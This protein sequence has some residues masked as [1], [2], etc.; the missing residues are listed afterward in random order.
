MHRAICTSIFV[1][2]AAAL[3][4]AGCKPRQE[5]VSGEQLRNLL[6]SMPHSDRIN[7][8]ELAKINNGIYLLDVRFAEEH[9]LYLVAA[10]EIRIEGFSPEKTKLPMLLTVGDLAL[11]TGVEPNISY[12]PFVTRKR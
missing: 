10:E 3:L 2:I 11:R 7:K 1:V 4:L 6:T 5:K 12:Q 8:M 9:V